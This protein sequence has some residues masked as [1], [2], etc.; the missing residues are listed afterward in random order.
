VKQI[1]A[2]IEKICSMNH[3]FILHDTHEGLKR[4]SW[5]TIW[6]HGTESD[7]ACICYLFSPS[8]SQG[9][10]EIYMLSTVGHFEEKL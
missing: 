5:E 3:N 8:I 6:L 9:R 1:K 2:E 10:K 7:N 4:F